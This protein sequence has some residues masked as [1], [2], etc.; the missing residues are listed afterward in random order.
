[1]KMDFTVIYW[2]T[3]ILIAMTTQAIIFWRLRTRK[4]RRYEQK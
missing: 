3:F 2:L 4:A 1:M